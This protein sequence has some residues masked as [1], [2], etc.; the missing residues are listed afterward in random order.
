MRIT[1]TGKSNSSSCSCSSSKHEHLVGARVRVKV[2]VT[3][4]I[5]TASGRRRSRVSKHL[6]CLCLKLFMSQVGW[7]NCGTL[8]C[9]TGPLSCESRRV[10]VLDG[11]SC[12]GRNV[13][14]SF[15]SS[16]FVSSL[17]IFYFSAEKW[18]LEQ[19]CNILNNKIMRL[20]KIIKFAID[21]WIRQHCVAE[22]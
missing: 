22:A 15:Q 11:S 12:G 17:I 19:K 10:A 9:K 18:N 2:T 6:D 7:N 20:N 13:S 4:T 3:T 5:K 14:I 16:N 8:W 1:V 21:K